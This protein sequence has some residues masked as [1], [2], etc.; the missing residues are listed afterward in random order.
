MCGEEVVVRQKGSGIG[1]GTLDRFQG[2]RSQEFD[3]RRDVPWVSCSCVGGDLACSERLQPGVTGPSGCASLVPMV[4]ATN[5]RERHDA[6][7]RWR[8]DATWR[9]CMQ[10]CE[11]DGHDSRRSACIGGPRK[12]EGNSFRASRF[13]MWWRLGSSRRYPDGDRRRRDDRHICVHVIIAPKSRG[14]S[15]RRISRSDCRYPLDCA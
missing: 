5:L 2:C 6:T 9:G 7:F 14:Q 4:K 3:C 11:E 13:A 8:L 12:I 10:E 15:R 1:L